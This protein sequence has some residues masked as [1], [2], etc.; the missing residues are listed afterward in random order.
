M[1]ICSHAVE[2]GF[3]LENMKGFSFLKKM[4]NFTAV[5]SAS[6][7][8]NICGVNCVKLSCQP[9]GDVYRSLSERERIKGMK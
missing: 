5:V 3:L 6:K 7:M 8:F 9:C 4:T 1:I 2:L